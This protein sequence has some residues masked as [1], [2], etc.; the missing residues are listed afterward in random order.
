MPQPYVLGISEF[1]TMP[2]SFDDDVARY[3]KLEVGAIEVVETNLDPARIDEQMRSIAA[4]GR[5]PCSAWRS[6]PSAPTA[7]PLMNHVPLIAISTR[8]SGC[9]PSRRRL[10]TSDQTSRPQGSCHAG[11]SLWM[12]PS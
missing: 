10:G 3:A 6:V 8:P 5:R 4:D 2:W 7:L 1:T 9:Q 12:V 11:P